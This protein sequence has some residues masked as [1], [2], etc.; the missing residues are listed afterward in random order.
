VRELVAPL[1]AKGGRPSVDPLVF[2]QGALAV[3]FEGL[4]SERQLMRA[5]SD[6]LSVRSYLGY[7]LFE[8]LP[9]HSSLTRIR[10]TFGLSL[11]GRFFERIVQ[12]CVP[13]GLAW[14][15]ELSFDSTRVEANTNASVDST[16]SRR[17]RRRS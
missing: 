1:Y 15:E 7:N 14:G 5:V 4:R 13:A 12:E 6:R 11:I 10:E 16:R 17:L 2:L 8:P 3:F 9:D